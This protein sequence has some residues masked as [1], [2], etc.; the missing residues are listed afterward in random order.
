MRCSNCGKTEKEAGTIYLYAGWDRDEDLCG[1][2]IKKS[3][4][5]EF[6]LLFEGREDYN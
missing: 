3:E 6:E 1:D 2:C 4:L 5:E